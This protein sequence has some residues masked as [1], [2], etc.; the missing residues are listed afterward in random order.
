LGNLKRGSSRK[1]G[2]EDKEKKGQPVTGEDGKNQHSQTTPANKIP[3]EA[4]KKKK[5]F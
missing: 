1:K 3:W 2:T 5:K 4:K